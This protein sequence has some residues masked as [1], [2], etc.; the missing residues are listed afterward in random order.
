MITM[1]GI[2]A[3]EVVALVAGAGAGDR[4]E[5]EDSDTGEVTEDGLGAVVSSWVGRAGCCC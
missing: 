3:E 1:T 4:E 2:P 5:E